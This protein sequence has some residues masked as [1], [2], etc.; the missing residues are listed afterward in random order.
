MTR[1][2]H[3]TEDYVLLHYSPEGILREF[4][5]KHDKKVISAVFDWL[6]MNALCAWR[7]KNNKQHVSTNAISR[8][9]MRDTNKYD[10]VVLDRDRLDHAIEVLIGKTK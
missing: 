9:V 7:F 3:K 5:S 6:S 1:P 2:N 8:T 4:K 10:C